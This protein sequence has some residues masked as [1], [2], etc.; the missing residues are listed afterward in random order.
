MVSERA[1]TDAAPCSSFLGAAG[2]AD[3][4]ARP[5]RRDLESERDR[6]RGD[7]VRDRRLSRDLLRDRLLKK[8]RNLLRFSLS[9]YFMSNRQ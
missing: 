9:S 4:D 2:E 8:S 7:R 6:R 1:S 5:R 3:R